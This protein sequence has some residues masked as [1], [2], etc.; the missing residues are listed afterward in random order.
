MTSKKTTITKSTSQPKKARQSAKKT[1]RWNCVK[2]L[3]ENKTPKELLNV[4]DGLYRLSS[5]NA[6]YVDALFP[7]ADGG[8]LLEEHR[9]K[10]LK[11]FPPNLEFWKKPVPQLGELKKYIRNY[12]KGTNDRYGSIELTLTFYEG[13][14]GLLN[15]I[16]D[17]EPYINPLINGLAD[18]VKLFE[19]D[20]PQL[21]KLFSERLL[22]IGDLAAPNGYGLA[23]EVRDAV[24]EIFAG[25]GYRVE[26]LYDLKAFRSY[27]SEVEKI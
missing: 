15:E 10:L 24:V 7:A 22:K 8:V 21:F 13:A 26:R 12:W 5:E 20:D 4:I 11:A 25:F 2:K 3:L 1:K 18:L 9:Q 14:L 27:W 23:D 19:C 17:Y 6:E 16:G